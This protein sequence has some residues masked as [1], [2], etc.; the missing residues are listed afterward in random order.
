MSKSPRENQHFGAFSEHNG[1]GQK[2][3]NMIQPFPSHE[4]KNLTKL[5]QSKF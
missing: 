2:S 4:S 3:A 5:S 1:G